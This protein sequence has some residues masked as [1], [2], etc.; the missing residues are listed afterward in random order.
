[1][2]PRQFRYSPDLWPNS[3]LPVPRLAVP[4]EVVL[5]DAGWLRTG[6]SGLKV[7]FAPAEMHLR[8]M[9]D[10]DVQSADEIVALVGQVGSLLDYG[11]PW[12]GVETPTTMPTFA[13]ANYR[14]TVEKL[15]AQLGFDLPD[16]ESRPPGATHV[17]E[18]ATRLVLARRLVD[19][20]DDALAQRATA[21]GWQAI[22]F[23]EDL[24]S[25]LMGGFPP[26]G[27]ALDEEDPETLA[28]YYFANMI[29]N[30]LAE[31]SPRVAPPSLDS[32][33]D[34]GDITSGYTAACVLLFNDLVDSIPYR[35]CADETCGRI[36]RHQLGR[37]GGGFRRSEG[38]AFCT[39]QHA[40]SQSQR[41]RRRRARAERSE[42][43]E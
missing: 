33:P 8:E 43:A 7:G 39:P 5:D 30:G 24:D 42:G 2:P 31:V 34:L 21:P 26:D 22:G 4:G 6:H 19:H 27:R 29:N 32:W 36:F 12:A 14:T 23:F 15:G 3:R 41:E 20:V 17:S 9:R 37:S 13:L 25:P 16:W 40:R 38:V 18:E 11:R 28:W 35:R 10:V 1:M